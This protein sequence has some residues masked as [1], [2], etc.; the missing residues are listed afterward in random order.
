MRIVAK[1]FATGMALAT[2]TLAFP[3]AAQAKQCGWFA[4]GGC[5]KKPIYPAN[6]MGYFIFDTNDVEGFRNGLHCIAS[7]PQTRN[8]AIRDRNVLRSDWGVKDAYIKRGCDLK[9]RE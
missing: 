3:T 9:P 4:V 7:G 5:A 8:G 2:A 6:P 1:A